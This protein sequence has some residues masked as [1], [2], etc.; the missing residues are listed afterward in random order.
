M[1]RKTKG[2]LLTIFT[3]LAA[4][5]LLHYVV[6]GQAV[7]GDGI[8]YWAFTRSIYFDKNIDFSNEFTHQYSPTRNN[9]QL[10]EQQHTAQDVTNKY[11]IGAPL[12]W[13]GFFALA[14][15]LTVI[16]SLFGM[17]SRNGYADLYQIIVGFG[18]IFFVV[19]GVWILY[20]LLQVYKQSKLIILTVLTMLFGTNL[21][22]YASIDV[23]NS[24]PFSFFVSSVYFY[25]W[26]N[27]FKTK[28]TKDWLLLGGLLGLL[29][30][31]RNQDFVLGSLLIPELYVL[32]KSH[33]HSLYNKF[34][35]L[36][37]L[38]V[39]FSLML[40][41]QILVWNNL[42]GSV[43]NIPYLTG[44][45]AFDFLHPHLLGVFVN[46]DTGLLFYTPVFVLSL[47]GTGVLFKM[48]RYIALCL[49]LPFL[50]QYLLIASWSGWHQG[51]S[52]GMRMFLSLI[53]L[54]TLGLYQLVLTAKKYM[55]LSKIYAI[56]GM[57]VLYN[58]CLIF[59]YQI[60][61]QGQTIDMGKITQERSLD[62]VRSLFKSN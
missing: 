24:H 34:F 2:F 41:P 45:Q 23:I 39:V 53:P 21:F 48:N 59:V 40:L 60:F 44:N 13:L 36:F 35:A 32:M 31:T 1:L 12:A 50:L 28:T 20:K 18:N 42:Y 58:I 57:F 22:Y 6:V 56:C 38:F 33:T 4:I 37:G 54:F 51:E 55:S 47:F 25:F 5:F 29:T 30:L 9:S 10:P 27:T 46:F 17:F 62:F 15:I 61:L 7:Y 52:Y 26:Y 11:P 19:S 43:Q 3:I 49:I 16:L 14:D 8:Y